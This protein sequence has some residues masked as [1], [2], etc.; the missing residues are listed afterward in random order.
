MQTQNQENE[1]RKQRG[2]EIA[3]TMQ[4][5][6]RGK[7]GYVVPSQ[8]GHGAYLVRYKNHKPICECPDFEKR[9]IFGIVCKHCWAVELTIKKEIDANGTTTITKTMKVTYP[10]D[11]KNYDL[12]NTNQKDIFQS[13]LFDL[14][15]IIPKMPSKATGRP[16]LSIS[17]M[18]FTSALKVY[19]NFSLRRFMCDV[20]EAHE[21]GYIKQVPHYT[22][23]SKYMQ[24]PEMTTILQ[25]LILMSAL[26]LKSVETSFSIDASG[27][28]PSKFSRWFDKK[29]KAVRDR[30]IWYKLHLVNGNA[31]HIISSCKITTQH[32]HDTLMLEELTKV[33]HENFD[34]QELCADKGYLSQPN[35][36]HLNRLGVAA[37]IPFKS[38]TIADNEKKSEIWRNAYNYFVFNQSAFLA[39][40]H[41][42][43]NSETVFH[44]VKSKFGYSVRSKNDTA[45]INEIL[46][47]VLCHNICVLISEM[48]ELGIQ[49][50]FFMQSYST[51]RG[52]F[53][54]K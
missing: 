42:R 17:D 6:K 40:Y 43:S 2:M 19:T 35:L 16:R 47:K 33:T 13:L 46:L 24:K 4:I 48:Y 38:N 22:L 27:I 51:E 11:W 41:Q 39:K 8:S 45:C 32:V 52:D 31:T 3:Q 10:Q 44:M 14:C 23:P 18:V 54:Q 21:R 49:P 34:M 7:G 15:K 25:D 5:L 20:K 26:P 29:Y 9:N 1:V 28:S 50:E 37:Y 53:L 12:A 30:K 36:E